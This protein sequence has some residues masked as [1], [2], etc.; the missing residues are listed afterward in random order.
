MPPNDTMSLEKIPTRAVT[1]I[2]HMGESSQ[3]IVISSSR[4][5]NIDNDEMKVCDDGDQTSDNQ[6]RSGSDQNEDTDSTHEGIHNFYTL[7]VRLHQTAFICEW[8]L[9][10]YLSGNAFDQVDIFDGICLTEIG[11]LFEISKHTRHFRVEFVIQLF[12]HNL[13]VLSSNLPDDILYFV[14]FTLKITKKKAAKI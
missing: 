14:F 2:D 9:V 8:Q 13:G 7:N 5:R 10:K 12:F 3:S 1:H 4:D 6:T 11:Q